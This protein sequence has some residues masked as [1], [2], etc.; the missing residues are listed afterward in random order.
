MGWTPAGVISATIPAISRR[1][2]TLACAGSC[3]AS[4][5][6]G[7]RLG[8]VTTVGLVG[9]MP[10]FDKTNFSGSRAADVLLA[11]PG[12]SMPGRQRSIRWRGTLLQFIEPQQFSGTR[13]S[14]TCRGR[15]RW[16]GML[17]RH[18]AGCSSDAKIIRADEEPSAKRMVGANDRFHSFLVSGP[19]ADRRWDRPH[20]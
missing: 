10:I 11:R 12:K 4:A 5:I 16:D 3:A 17:V 1:A 2:P 9:A 18:A 19:V 6:H 8:Q 13:G 15:S 20:R 7:T 14:A